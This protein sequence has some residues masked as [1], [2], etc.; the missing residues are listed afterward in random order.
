MHAVMAPLPPMS[1]DGAT[2][3]SRAVRG[4]RATASRRPRQLVTPLAESSAESAVADI[5]ASLVHSTT[6]LSPIDPCISQAHGTRLRGR[7]PKGA[8]ALTA[9]L[10]AIGRCSSVAYHRERR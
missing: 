6:V 1:A 8:S 2:R 4:A 7:D 10:M 9:R 3:W 5:V